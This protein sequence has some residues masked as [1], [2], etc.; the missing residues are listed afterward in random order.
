MNLSFTLPLL[1]VFIATR[2]ATGQ[3]IPDLSK[4]P[5]KVVERFNT[6]FPGADVIKCSEEEE[7]TVVIYDFEFLVDGQK[8]E[9][10]ITENGLLLNWEKKIP[11]GALPDPVRKSARTRYPDGAI[12]EVMLITVASNDGE[13]VEGYEIV[14]ETREQKEVEITVA[15]DG[16]VL[17]DPGEE[18]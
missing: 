10:D 7:G 6:R 9:A 15:P 18:Q 17:E 14:L 12:K 16:T 5:P 13:K 11:D 8:L 4:V 1:L 3:E 2:P